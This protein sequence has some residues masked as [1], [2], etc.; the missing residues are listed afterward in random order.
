MLPKRSSDYF[1][2]SDF[3]NE[4]SNFQ[5]E[6]DDFVKAKGFV[7]SSYQY[8]EVEITKYFTIDIIHSSAGVIHY[9]FD[10]LP[11]FKYAKARG[12]GE[13]FG[14]IVYSHLKENDTDVFTAEEKNGEGKKDKI[15]YLVNKYSDLNFL[16][17]RVAPYQ[18]PY[19][20]YQYI[21]ET[22]YNILVKSN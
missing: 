15:I 20:I 19:G 6:N 11:V 18:G 12:L 7:E 14:R 22:F 16:G 4:F 5:L 3:Y 1:I 21:P 13:N 8:F 10:F 17:F 9:H 2:L